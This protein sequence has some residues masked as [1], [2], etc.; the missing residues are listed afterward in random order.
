MS[1][2]G[3]VADVD[4]GKATAST[5]A[6][7]SRWMWE[8]LCGGSGRFRILRVFSVCSLREGV[9]W[10]RGNAVWVLLFAFFV[11]VRESRRLLTLRLVLSCTIAEQGLHL[12]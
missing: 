9:A 7:R 1:R 5:I 11:E 12:Q 2:A 4:L 3:R 10:S 6:F 8:V